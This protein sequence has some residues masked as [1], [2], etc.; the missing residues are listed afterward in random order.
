MTLT[1]LY[2]V[3]HPLFFEIL[4]TTSIKTYST[5]FQKAALRVSINRMAITWQV[6]QFLSKRLPNQPALHKPF[7]SEKLVK[8]LHDFYKLKIDKAVSVWKPR[9]VLVVFVVIYKNLK[10]WCDIQL[11]WITTKTENGLWTETPLTL[12][13]FVSMQFHKKIFVRQNWVPHF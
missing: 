2:H 3:I 1:T 13:S 12:K 11:S 4:P 6:C 8:W 10:N 9:F 7:Q 5:H